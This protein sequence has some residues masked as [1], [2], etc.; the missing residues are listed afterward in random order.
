M[1]AGGRRWTENN[2]D[3]PKM[4]DQLERVSGLRDPFE[5]LR[6]ATEE[7]ASA[8]HTVTELARLRRRIIN[9]LRDQGFTY[10]QIATRAGLT[11]GRIHQIRTSSPATEGAFL[12]QGTL[13]IAT[14]LKQEDIRQRPV[15][16]VED[17]AVASRLS[18]LA[19]S[20][21]LEPSV[22]HVP[23]GGAIDLNRANLVVVCG[24]RLSED[25]AGVMAQDPFVGFE[26]AEDGPWTLVDHTTGKRYR[27]GQDS[28]PQRPTD[29]AYLARLPRPDGRGSVLVFTGIHPQGS[30]GVTHLLMTE[31]ANLYAQVRTANFSVIVGTDYD[32]DTS[33]PRNVELL[34]P[35]YLHK[36]A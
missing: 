23:I 36:D 16:A 24:P 11:R 20:L 7:M 30:L 18:D 10:A 28:Q 35:L 19:R 34:T 14:P 4:S 6:A 15:V 22:E 32:P 26:R 13:T 31:L 27:S 25:V 8:Q 5:Q 2:D 9:D 21:D 29:V 1:H 33:E 17:V 12:G 3:G